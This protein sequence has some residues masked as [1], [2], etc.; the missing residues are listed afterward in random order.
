MKKR[1]LDELKRNGTSEAHATSDEYED[2]FEE[3]FGFS[4]PSHS[5][6]FLHSDT[7]TFGDSMLLMT[8][9]AFNATIRQA[10]ICFTQRYATRRPLYYAILFQLVV[11]YLV[12]WCGRS[13]HPLMGPTLASLRSANY[14]EVVKHFWSLINRGDASLHDDAAE[15]NDR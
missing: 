12:R 7:P 2:E 10:I 11:E 14:D 9:D 4:F 1:I 5:V 6:S 3:I 15:S 8:V 13:S